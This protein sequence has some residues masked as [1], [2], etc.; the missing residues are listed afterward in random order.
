MY[1]CPVC[2]RKLRKHED[3]RSARSIKER[4]CGGPL[5]RGKL[6]REKLPKTRG[7]LRA[8]GSCPCWK[9]EGAPKSPLF[10]CLGKWPA[11]APSG[12]RGLHLGATQDGFNVSHLSVQRSVDLKQRLPRTP[13]GATHSA[14]L[15]SW[16]V[17]KRPRRTIWF[18]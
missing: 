15:W 4:A 11:P 16:W 12:E 9:G 10:P 13:R 17:N 5:C 7:L 6:S 8:P 3:K 2:T 14:P 1:P 18:S